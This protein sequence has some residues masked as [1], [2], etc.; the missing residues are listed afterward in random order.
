MNGPSLASAH[1][2][3]PGTVIGDYCVKKFV[4]QGGM[5][6]V[7]LVT[8]LKL[9]KQFALKLILPIYSQEPT[10]RERFDREAAVLARL[11]HPNIVSVV[12]YGD[13]RGLPYL[14]MEYLQGTKL[15]D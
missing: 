3:Q 11:E 8:H 13:H 14:V 7:Y 9:R 1:V 15:S 2:L 10:F 12:H 4:G 5:G 6:V